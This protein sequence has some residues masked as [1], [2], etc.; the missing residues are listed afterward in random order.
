[1]ATEASVP[2]IS[3]VEGVGSLAE[4]LSI[5]TK[6]ERLVQVPADDDESKRG[7]AGQRQTGSYSKVLALDI[8]YS[9]RSELAVASGVLYKYDPAAAAASRGSS[10]G[11]SRH[12][13]AKEDKNILAEKTSSGLVRFPYHPG[14]LA[15][16][17]IPLLSGILKEF[18]PPKDIEEPGGDNDDDDAAAADNKSKEEIIL[19]CDGA[20][21]AHPRFCGLACHLGVLYRRPSIGVAKNHLIGDYSSDESTLCSQ[22]G[23]QTVLHYKGRSVGTVLRTQTGVR[24]LFISPGHLLSIREANDLVLGLCHNYRIP[25]P[26]RRAD[27]IGRMELKRIE[28]QQ[29]YKSERKTDARPV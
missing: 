16:R 29:E 22:R 10:E 23:D 20:G 24:P 9:T 17:E 3:E 15:F 5:Q 11:P 6:I 28:E 26:L 14:Y 27:H 2:S 12:S 25:E 7:V 21:I 1:M 19:L 8:A 4:A 18:L 13:P